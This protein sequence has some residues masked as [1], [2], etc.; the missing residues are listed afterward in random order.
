MQFFIYFTYLNIFLNKNIQ[1]C[2]K[3]FCTENSSELK[4]NEKCKTVEKNINSI[5]ICL[6]AGL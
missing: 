6:E 1:G 5:K 4:K 2:S 3:N